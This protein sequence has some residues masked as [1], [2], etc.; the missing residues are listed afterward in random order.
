M[1]NTARRTGAARKCS[2]AP[3]CRRGALPYGAW[4]DPYDNPMSVNR[5]VSMRLASRE[6][7]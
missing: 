5:G 4:F 7:S 2:G 1:G 6:L 3:H